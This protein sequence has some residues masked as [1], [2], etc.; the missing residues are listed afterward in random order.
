MP[1]ISPAR[2]TRYRRLPRLTPTTWALTT[3]GLLIATITWPWL[4]GSLTAVTAVA[5]ITRAIRPARLNPLWRTLDLIAEHRRTLPTGPRTLHHFQRL[6]PT[7]FERAIAELALEHP[8]IHSAAH[9]G[10][11]GDNGADV[12]LQHIDG[13]RTLIQ[14]KLYRP[15][16]NVGSDTIHTTNGVY[17]DLH[18]CQRAVIVT[19]AGYTKSALDTNMRLPQPIRLVD[20]PALVAWANGAIPPWK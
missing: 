2:P 9:T 20:G 5:L 19:T 12:L 1:T 16:N 4:V 7:G 15:G 18:G 3:G 8:D 14:T 17:R 13:T 11:S 10:G 6:T